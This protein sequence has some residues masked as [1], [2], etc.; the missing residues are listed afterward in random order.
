MQQALGQAPW[1]AKV[2]KGVQPDLDR[3]SAHVTKGRCL[4]AAM[5]LV[6]DTHVYLERYSE[7]SWPDNVLRLVIDPRSVR[8]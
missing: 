8:A 2:V 1:K 5:L 3:L 6:D 7:L 4:V